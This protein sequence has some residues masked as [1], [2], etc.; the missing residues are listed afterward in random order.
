MVLH[1]QQKNSNWTKRFLE[2]SSAAKA[3]YGACDGALES[4][5]LRLVGSFN[6][7]K[8]YLKLA[9]REHQTYHEFL[10]RQKNAIFAS[11]DYYRIPYRKTSDDSFFWMCWVIFYRKSYSNF[12]FSKFLKVKFM[13][14]LMLAFREF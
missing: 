7:S 2:R 12:T 5:G 11:D 1:F 8:K 13:I 14:R 3:S 10:Y 6:R 4:S 9:K